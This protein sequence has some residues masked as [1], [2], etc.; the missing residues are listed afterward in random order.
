LSEI[1]ITAAAPED[2]ILNVDGDPFA[3]K[4]HV[5]QYAI[6]DPELVLSDE[7]WKTWSATAAISN[8]EVFGPGGILYSA[9]ING[10]PISGITAYT[11]SGEYSDDYGDLTETRSG[12]LAAF[13]TE[14]L[15]AIGVEYANAPVIEVVK[16]DEMIT[17]SESSENIYFGT[18][19]S[20]YTG[21]PDADDYAE[22][23]KF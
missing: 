10:Y 2:I 5:E 13:P 6:M 7:D 14:L 8:D 21:Y 12:I 15:E 9:R 20:L 16:E 1:T 18:V 22:E 17:Y 23:D 11:G 3:L 4:L 19:T